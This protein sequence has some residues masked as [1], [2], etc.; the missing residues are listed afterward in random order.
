MKSTVEQ[1]TPTRVK[2]NVEVPFEELSAEFDRTYRS[3]AQQI[4]I[5]GFRPGKAP[6]KLIEARVGRDSILAQVVNDALPGKYSEAVA[7]TETK[8]I[9]QPEIDLSELKYGESVT[10]T[11]EVDVRPEID[12]PDY[13]T[14][15]V[16]VDPIEIEDD[17]VDEQLEGL[18]ARFGTLKGVDRGAQDGD[19]VSID[20]AAEVDG[21]P[22]DEASTE[23]LSHEVG[24]GQ[25]IDGL[26]EA[27]V[28]LKAGDSKVFT[29]KLV[30]GD[31]AGEDAQVTVT[32]NSVKERELPEVD[33]EF[34][35]MASEFDTVDE[36]KES[37]RE[38]VTQ[39]KKVEQANAIRDKVLDAL[40]DTV[41]VPLPE[42]VVEGEIEGQ[43]HQVI[44]ALG[45][46]DEQLAKFLEAQGTTRE[47]W[48]AEART[49]AEKS[50]RTQLLLD[51]IA[52]QQ[53]TEVS[54]DELTQQIIFQA[55]RYGMQPQEFIQQ[56]TQANQVGAVY[57]DVRRGKALA[58][59]VGQVTVTDTN[60]ATV[61]TSEFFGD[62]NDEAAA[63]DA[64]SDD[65]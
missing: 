12:L 22:V 54:Q 19:F 42:K 41:E 3:L 52:E 31:H 43:Q 30:A 1:L 57:A 36:L 39:S 20:L 50:V 44:H 61:D 14:L 17:A 58:G 60:G 46:D 29:T 47:E 38:R 25:L 4:R 8:A 34:A 28:G 63:D 53:E 18:R 48:D 56:L 13:S 49:E 35:Q 7:E 24:S 9:G 33:D 51:A 10:F 27:L 64:T 26:D 5:P 45:H 59:I 21:E 37:L 11:A 65:A 2:L 62:D 40:L 55:Q 15:A 16:E 32:V 23:G 6:A